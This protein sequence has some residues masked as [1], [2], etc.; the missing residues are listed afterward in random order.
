M[1]TPYPLSGILLNPEIP[2]K[3]KMRKSDVQI[4]KTGPIRANYYY[5]I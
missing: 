5:N 3:H 2:E 1:K 4:I